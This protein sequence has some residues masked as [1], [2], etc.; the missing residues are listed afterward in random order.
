VG[1]LGKQVMILVGYVWLTLCIAHGA[2][3]DQTVDPVML[4][5]AQLQVWRASKDPNANTPPLETLVEW[6]VKRGYPREAFTPQALK[7]VVMSEEMDL[8]Q[9]VPPEGRPGMVAQIERRSGITRNELAASIPPAG[10]DRKAMVVQG[11][12][13]KDIAKEKTVIDVVVRELFAE[14]LTSFVITELNKGSAADSD[15]VLSFFRC[16]WSVAGTRYL[17]ERL[18]DA[19]TDELRKRLLAVL[20]HRADCP[21]EFVEQF[22]QVSRTPEMLDAVVSMIERACITGNA[23]AENLL[24]RLLRHSSIEVR[25]R[26]IRSLARLRSPKVVDTLVAAVQSE[27]E[28][29]SQAEAIR[30]LQPFAGHSAVTDTLVKLATSS[31]DQEVRKAALETIRLDL[32]STAEKGA[33]NA[34]ILRKLEEATS[35][36]TKEAFD[37]L[38]SRY[39][40]DAERYRQ[41]RMSR[42]RMATQPR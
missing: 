20:E 27:K 30:S 21:V 35:P 12:A 37:A 42:Q 39:E 6:Q 38:K 32:P 23:D 34:A 28:P 11:L 18:R 14:D 2:A 10:E 8:L 4:R 33:T 31:P 26:A 25:K 16:D 36:H 3:A 1:V 22:L 9:K 13:G 24:I 29:G 17:V 5:I 19:K 40:A 15:A 7:Q 41:R